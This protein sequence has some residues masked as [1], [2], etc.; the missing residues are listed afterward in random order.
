MN[1]GWKIMK[2]KYRNNNAHW[3]E[4]LCITSLILSIRLTSFGQP[5]ITAE[6]QSLTNVVGTTAAFSVT[7]TGAEPLNYEWEQNAAPLSFGTNAELILTNIQ[8]SRAGNYIVVITNLEGAAT[9]AVATLTVWI[10]PTIK[11]LT[12][13]SVSLGANVT[14]RSSVSGTSP[15][16][17]QW[18]WS[19]APL[20]GM[21]KDSLVLTNARMSDAGIYALVVTNFAGAA[22]NSVQLEVDPTFTKITTGSIVNDGGDSNGCAWGD[23]DDDGFID[24][25][26]ANWNT[27]LDGR[28]FLYH[29][30]GDGT[31]TR[32]TVGPEVNDVGAHCAASWVDFDNDGHLDLLVCKFDLPN[33]LYRNNGDGSFTQANNLLARQAQRSAAGVWGDF[34]NDGWLDLFIANVS[35]GPGMLAQP[36]I[37]YQSDGNGDFKPISFGTKPIGEGDSFAAAWGDFDND[38]YLDLIVSQ[39]GAYG[40]EHALL[41]HNNRDG[42]FA[43]LTNS[44]VHASGLP[45]EGCAWGDFNN[46]GW[47]DLYVGNFYGSNNCLFLNNGDGTFS[48]ITNSVVTHDGGYTKNVTWVDYD[49]DGWL[50]LFMAHTGPYRHA[51]QV[52]LGEES[53]FLY[54]NNGDG[55]FTKVTSGSLVNDLGNFCGSA[56]GD[57]D[58]DGFLDLFV[59]NGFVVFSRNNLLYH[60]NG[61][62]NAWVNFR[63]IG[64]LSNRSAI[65]AKVRLKATIHGRTF[66]QMREISGGSG[67]GSQNDIRANFGLGDAT[68]VDL[69]RIEWPSGVVQTL[70][71]VRPRQFLT[72]FEHQEFTNASAR[73][74]LSDI[75]RQTNGAVSLTVVGDAGPLYLLEASTNLVNW[76][77]LSV[78]SNATGTV[79]FSDPRPPASSRRFY[80]VSIP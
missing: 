20:A 13:Q 63:L 14:F 72:V 71:N 43:P 23:Y 40:D 77:R 78:R 27:D 62:S 79:Q 69:V 56:W 8:T 48:Q 74:V 47:L 53:S 17:Y 67:F 73:P 39:G 19:G 68:N 10:P 46:D 50:D 41:Y 55:T 25:F 70:T 35:D 7:A 24:L 31:F 3:G 9:S 4:L 5:V 34:D 30:N 42:T 61:N 37:L 2:P 11:P 21:T 22:T 6:P 59:A 60:N 32:I 49:N 15:F 33:T 80:R 28:D 58:N 16:H 29:N 44:V 45:H 18:F 12:N 51:G 36:N 75:S 57:Y 54:H 76:A 66:W 64:T 52:S 38:G 1:K 65:G 26:V